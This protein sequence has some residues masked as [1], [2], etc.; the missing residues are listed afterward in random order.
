[1]Q[2]PGNAL[3]CLTH[4]PKQRI[5]ENVTELSSFYSVSVCTHGPGALE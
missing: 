3:Q 1:M 2:Q 4:G 5:W